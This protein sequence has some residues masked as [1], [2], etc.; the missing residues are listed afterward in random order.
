MFDNLRSDF[1]AHGSSWSSQGFW[2]MIV[3]RF[4]NWRYGIQPR[5]LRLPFSALYKFLFVVVQVAT[6]VEL[7][8]EAKVGRNFIIDHFG[9]I[10]ISG[11]AQ[12]GDNCRVRTGVVI[13]LA[14]VDQPC[15]PRL[16]NNVDVGAGAKLLGDITIGDNVRIGANA[17]VVKDVPADCTAVG[18][19]ARVRPI[20]AARGDTEQEA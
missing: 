6:G 11:Y 20:G 18:I 19:P 16:G 3:Y 15:A 13:G 5:L 8:C 17:V 7:P 14:R 12:I 4:G 1:R 2:V 9:G 10:I